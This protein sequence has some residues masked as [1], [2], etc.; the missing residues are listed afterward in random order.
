MHCF[1][2]FQDFKMTYTRRSPEERR[3]IRST[4]DLSS[5]EYPNPL[6]WN[7][8]AFFAVILFMS[9]IGLPQRLELLD[10]ADVEILSQHLGRLEQVLEYNGKALYNYGLAL[11]MKSSEMTSSEMTSSEK[12]ENDF[13]NLKIS[14]AISDCKNTHN[15]YTSKIED[16]KNIIQTTNW[17]I[18]LYFFWIM[19]SMLFP[20]IIM[21]KQ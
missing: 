21:V 3:F 8:K 7:W 16:V 6:T 2:Q 5:T 15:E 14:S 9:I 4:N 11:K 1:S 20:M 13:W 18:Y 19:L 17:K 10:D 12:T